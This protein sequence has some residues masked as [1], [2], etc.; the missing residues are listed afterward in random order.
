MKK[1]RPQ[2]GDTKSMSTSSSFKA[3]TSTT[4]KKSPLMPKKDYSKGKGKNNEDW[5][6]DIS[7]G[8]TGLTGE[9]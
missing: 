8:Q 1:P 4:Q 5:M 9:S 6:H 3:S 7:F 2:S